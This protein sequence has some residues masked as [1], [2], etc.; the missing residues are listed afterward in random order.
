MKLAALTLLLFLSVTLSFSQDNSYLIKGKVV[1]TAASYTMVNSTVTIL[2]QKDS[3]LVKFSRVAQDGTF[4]VK[5]L[6]SGKFI[7]LITYP[8]YADY[9][10][11][12]SLDSLKRE[13]D[14][15]SINLV[16]KSTLLE[17]VIIQGK[18]AAI[19]IKGDTTEF[20]AGS[21]NIQPNSK[22]E[23]LLKQLPGMQIDKDGNITAQGKAVKKVLVDGEEFFGDD[24]TL[25]TKNIRADMVDK[26]QLY[27]KKSDEAAFTGVDDGVENKTINIK[28][29]EDKKNGYFGKVDLGAGTDKFYQGQAMINIFKGKQRISGYGIFGNTGQTGL[30]WEDGDKYGSSGGTQFEDGV[31]YIGG[32]DDLG[33]WNGRYDGRGIPSTKTGGLHFED[34]WNKDKF[35]LN[36][37]YKIGSLGVKGSSSNLT[38]NILPQDANGVLRT[39]NSASAQQFDNSTF[40][41]KLDA[42]LNF[43]LDSTS[44]LK[45]IIDGTQKETKTREDFASFSSRADSS[46]INTGDRQ[47]TNDADQNLFNINAFYTKKLKKKGR[48]L[49]ATLTQSLNQNKSNGF[50]NSKNEFFN[51]AEQLDS[52]RNIDQSKTNNSLS[53]ILSSRITY[54]EPISKATSVVFNY[55][56]NLNNSTSDKKSF[57]KS[58]TGLYDQLDTLFSNNFKLNQLTNQGGATVNI[59]KEKAT[60]NFG[61]NV[62]AV[63]F[64]QLDLYR[65]RKFDRNFINWNPNASYRYRFSQQKSLSINYYGYNTQPSISQI[66]PIREN[67]DPLNITIGNPDLNPSFNNRVSMGYNSYKILTD[68]YI[69]FYGSYSFIN[70]AI[71]NTTF[72]DAAGNNTYQ[73]INLNETPT[74]F[75]FNGS[76]SRKIK[77]I[78][79]SVGLDVSANGS[80]NFSMINGVLATTRSNNYSTGLSISQNKD[81]YDFRISGGPSY[82]DSRSSLPSSRNNQG[83]GATGNA[84]FNVK[85]PGKVQISSDGQYKFTAKTQT[86]NQ[87]FER[88]IINA[89]IAK[90][91]FKA[92]NLQIRIAVNDLLN[93]NVG[94]DR[95]SSNNMFIENRYTT[96]QRYFMGSIIWDFNK[97]GGTAKK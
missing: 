94:F 8:G 17:N 19:K 63:Q 20:N 6:R 45:L 37:N 54:T 62:S 33:G 36:T 64:R 65:N 78:E 26:V 44:T 69:Y 25:V 60:I 59:K 49:S 72:T 16:L 28:L 35:G 46:L 68:Q 88:I 15:N 27:D 76:T 96:I 84:S 74:N 70:N 56:L 82:N 43:Q 75:Y 85:L 71:T 61:T 97:M 80:K 87:D 23:D 12:F 32:G 2:N 57:N 48:T 51:E 31:Y 79:L 30:G 55:G 86:F 10:E 77:A 90:K 58:G 29:K 73:A 24:P 66:Q 22:V 47:V 81:K 11:Q 5:N 39:I 91:F 4:Q 38:Q 52:M 40:R 13:K 41:Q 89:F 67:T 1:D 93:Q 18:V 21:Y 50:L 9:A 95:S 14:F 92:E 34:K 83:W 3:T 7:L 42:T 53:S